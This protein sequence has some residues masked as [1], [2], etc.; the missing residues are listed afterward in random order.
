MEGKVISLEERAKDEA[1]SYLEELLSEGARKL[2]QRAVE[3]EVAEYLEIH[4][5][6]RTDAGQRAIVR[7]GHHPERELVTGIGPIKV[8]QPR[9]RHRDG[10]KFSSAILPPYMRRVPSIDGDLGRAGQRIISHQCRTPQSRLGRR[11]QGLVQAR[12]E[13][14]TLRLLVGRWNLLQRA[15]R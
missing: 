15:A 12:L 14:Q 4:R 5:E 13:C 10:Q 9:I 1:K 11:I 3:N 2:L 6:R 8:R 7:N